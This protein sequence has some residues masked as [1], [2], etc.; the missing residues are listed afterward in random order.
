[1]RGVDVRIIV[2]KEPDNPMVKLAAFSYLPEL[3][4]AGVK[5]FRYVGAF[6]HQKVMLVDDKYSS[7]GTANFDN[8][9]F[10][11]NFEITAV[12]ADVAFAK[13]VEGMLTNDLSKCETA[14]AKDL[15]DS[16]F[17]FRFAVRVARL[18]APVQ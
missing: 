2:P 7:V 13:Q 15:T 18:T 16:S 10:R 12:I 6:M 14:S 3:E 5:T 8:R 1:M 17:G 11:L 9:S 4:K